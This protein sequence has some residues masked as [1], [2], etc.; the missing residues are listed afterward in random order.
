[1]EVRTGLIV[2]SATDRTPSDEHWAVE[3]VP[4][5]RG[6]GESSLQY[7]VLIRM[8]ELIEDEALAPGSVVTLRGLARML[9]TST[10]PIR[11]ALAVLSTEGLTLP[12][13]AQGWQVAPL[14]AGELEEL[15]MT[16]LGLEGLAA[17]LGTERI[18]AESLDRMRRQAAQLG[19][20]S[21]AQDFDAFLRVD[22][23]FHM[24]H[25]EAS[26]RP[27]LVRRVRQLWRNSGRYN[28]RARQSLAGTVATHRYHREII[29]ACEEHDGDL[30]EWL[31]RANLDATMVYIRRV[32][33]GDGPYT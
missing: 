10:L 14:D 33:F 7:R 17:R 19:D 11:S 16:R 18:S 3:R 2:P 31:A 21:A 24:T 5:P 23:E 30:A 8:R 4:R 25:Y 22:D 27:S 6:R 29:A 20:A 1:M 32:L 28:R 12:K 26:N 9:G 13:G 15:Y